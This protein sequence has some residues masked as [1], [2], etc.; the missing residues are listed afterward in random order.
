MKTKLHSLF[1][2]LAYVLRGLHVVETKL[3]H[4]F[5][6]RADQI[7]STLVRSEI[8]GYLGGLHEN[9]LGI[10]QIFSYL[11]TNKVERKDHVV[12]ELIHEFNQ[13]FSDTDQSPM[14]DIFIVSS[15]RS[16]SAY[17][18]S[19]YHTAYQITVELELE[20]LAGILQRVLEKE[21]SA[22]ERLDK[23]TLTQFTNVR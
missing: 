18:K 19:L 2:L 15:V 3:I 22:C 7:T 20:T 16:I 10:E 11:M 14:K 17:K 1:D 21:E 5:G 8:D 6:L 12:Q 23:L 4:D 9:L 13:L